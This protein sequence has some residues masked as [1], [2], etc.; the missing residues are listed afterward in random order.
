LKEA[1]EEKAG[2]QQNGNVKTANNKTKKYCTIK[3]A[4]E[5]FPF[6]KKYCF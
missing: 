1:E 6:Q 2:M 3:L 4:K 5:I